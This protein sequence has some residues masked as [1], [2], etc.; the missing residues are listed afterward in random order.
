MSSSTTELH[1]Q[2]IMPPLQY[3]ILYQGLDEDTKTT[4]EQIC[5]STNRE[6]CNS[7][8]LLAREKGKMYDR[9]PTPVQDI[10]EPL[11]S[12]LLKDSNWKVGETHDISQNPEI[13]NKIEDISEKMDELRMNIE[14][15][16]C[17]CQDITS[18]RFSPT[19]CHG[20]NLSENFVW[21]DKYTYMD[22]ASVDTDERYEVKCLNNYDYKQHIDDNHTL[23]YNCT[24]Q[25]WETKGPN[26]DDPFV[27]YNFSKGRIQCSDDRD[28]GFQNIEGLEEGGGDPPSCSENW[29]LKIFDRRNCKPLPTPSKKRKSQ[30]SA[31]EVITWIVLL[32]LSIISGYLIYKGGGNVPLYVI[33]LSFCIAI[34]IIIRFSF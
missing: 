14:R 32:I 13:L 9:L 33:G 16:R 22:P 3:G 2:M 8:M 29:F 12:S 15:P 34:Y 23:L 7:P 28:E 10:P 5:T 30:I 4:Y 31:T 26:R 17:G 18:N 25:T 11:Y 19:R 27:E 24:K 6:G 21:G 20:S 1:S